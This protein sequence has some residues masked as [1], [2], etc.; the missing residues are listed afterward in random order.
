MMITVKNIENLL[1]QMDVLEA[2]AQTCSAKNMLLE[3]SQNSQ[4]NP[5]ARVSVLIKLQT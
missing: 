1:M 4:E 3:I 2:V 5:C